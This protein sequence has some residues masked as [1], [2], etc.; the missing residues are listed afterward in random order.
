[1]PTYNPDWTNA[2]LHASEAIANG[3]TEQ[4][5]LDLDT[6]GYYA[7]RAQIDIDIAS[8][9]PAGDVVIEVFTSCNGGTSVDTEPAQRAT[10]SFTAT[11]NK[12]RTLLIANTPWARVKVTN[13]TGVSV[14]YVGRYSGLK[15][16][17]A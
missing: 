17:S 7:I 4:D 15:Q 5:D 14:T 9:S 8:G 16:V 13:N 1:V 11:G 10:L 2:T 6:L 12:K 3:G